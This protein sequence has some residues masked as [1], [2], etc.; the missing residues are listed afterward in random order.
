M[1]DGATIFCSGPIGPLLLPPGPGDLLIACDGGYQNALDLG[2]S[3]GIWVGDG[4]SYHLPLPPGLE[5][6]RVGARKDDTDLMLAVK[7][8]LSRGISRMTLAFSLGGRL[9][10]TVATLQTLSYITRAGGD[11]VAFGE[12]AVAALLAGG[13][14]KLD[15]APGELLSLFAWNGDVTG[16]TTKGLLYP[17]TDAILTGGFPLGVSNA[18]TGPGAEV[19]AATGELLVIRSLGCSH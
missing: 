19:S 15:G 6:I 11:A 13:T 17:L 7:L 4:D 9:D 5:V 1:T 10:Q 18:F 2:F 3:P 16:V 14:L 8:A 12:G